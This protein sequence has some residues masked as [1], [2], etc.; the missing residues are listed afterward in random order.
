MII[1]GVRVGGRMVAGRGGRGSV[2]WYGK[3]G[4]VGIWSMDKVHIDGGMGGWVRQYLYRMALGA[5][6]R[7][8]R[9]LYRSTEYFF[10]TLDFFGCN[11]E[12]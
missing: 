10:K 3:D 1:I 12:I 11:D 4:K 6:P 5:V 9:K 8:R 7:S 2:A